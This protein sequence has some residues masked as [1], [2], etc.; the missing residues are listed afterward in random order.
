M[1]ILDKIREKYSKW[2]ADRKEIV[3]Q[4]CL[5]YMIYGNRPLKPDLL[6]I[7]E[8]YKMEFKR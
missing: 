6:N 4:R 8:I 5:D 2:E 3:R 1:N 7:G